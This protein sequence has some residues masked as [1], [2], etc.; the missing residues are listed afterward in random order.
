M[1]TKDNMCKS[2]GTWQALTSGTTIILLLPQL[3]WHRQVGRGWLWQLDTF[4][5][6]VVLM[7]PEVQK[8]ECASWLPK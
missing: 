5:L 7:G 8:A 4:A 2:S 3:P 1:K 6:V